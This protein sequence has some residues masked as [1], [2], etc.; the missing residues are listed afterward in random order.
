MKTIQIELPQNLTKDFL[1]DLSLHLADPVFEGTADPVLEFIR[2]NAVKTAVENAID[3]V[4]PDALKKAMS[5][6]NDW[7]DRLFLGATL[8]LREGSLRLDYSDDQEWAELDNQIKALS[9]KRKKREGILKQQY[10]KPDKETGEMGNATYKQKG[11]MILFVQ[12][13]E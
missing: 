5:L 2:L 11:D 4:K 13:P 1:H 3:Y 12:F 10:L 8:V 9:D 7:R 6:S